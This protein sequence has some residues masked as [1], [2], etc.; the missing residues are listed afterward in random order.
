MKKLFA[1]LS[2]IT[3]MLI[4]LI[5]FII[6]TMIIIIIIINVSDTIYLEIVKICPHIVMQ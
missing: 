5:M 6:M 3:T 1:K 2:I 4:T